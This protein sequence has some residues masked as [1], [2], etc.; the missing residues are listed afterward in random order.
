MSIQARISGATAEPR[1]VC[2]SAVV[3][4][5]IVLYPSVPFNAPRVL[6]LLGRFSL[7]SFPV[8]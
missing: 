3:P 6:P 4:A 5:T 7:H 1:I 8:G 2:L